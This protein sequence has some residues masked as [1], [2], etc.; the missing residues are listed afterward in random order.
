MHKNEELGEWL[1]C[2]FFFLF[3]SSNKASQKTPRGPLASQLLGFE[4]VKL[5]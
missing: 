5:L 3:P 4:G 2:Y 1:E